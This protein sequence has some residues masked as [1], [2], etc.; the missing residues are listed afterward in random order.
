MLLF[1]LAYLGGVLTLVSPYI[2]PMIR[3]RW[4]APTRPFLHNSLPMLIGMTLAFA[5]VASFASVAG[6]WVV[7]TAGLGGRIIEYTLLFA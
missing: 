6:G 1:F 7:K 3:S 2:L 4:R 5:V